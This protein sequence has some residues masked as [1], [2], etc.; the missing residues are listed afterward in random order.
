MPTNAIL[1]ELGRLSAADWD[2]TTKRAE[3]LM[4]SHNFGCSEAI[5]LAFQTA[6]PE[7]IPDALVAASTA[8]RGGMGGAGCVCGALAGGQMVL[9]AVFGYRGGLEGGATRDVEAAAKI[10]TLSKELHDRFREEHKAACCRIL[11][12]GLE[13]NSPERQEN[14]KRLVTNVATL[15]GC[16]IARE[17]A[18]V[19]NR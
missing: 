8:L 13:H 7:Y 2:K 12:K 11:T 1:K 5:I 10:R 18:E 15:T 9:G 3:K 6:M 17:A 19:I 14:C 4:A 16:I